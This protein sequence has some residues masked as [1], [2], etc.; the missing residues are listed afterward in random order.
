MQCACL[1]NH[2]PQLTVAAAASAAAAAAAAS[3]FKLLVCTHLTYH[4][5]AV[6]VHV[7]TPYNALLLLLLAGC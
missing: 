2:T 5:C 6:P 3:H 4:S 7:T 1:G